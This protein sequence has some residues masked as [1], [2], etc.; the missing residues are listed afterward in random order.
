MT[1]PWLI[2]LPLAMS[3]LTLV[4]R[5]VRLVTTPLTAA[6]FFALAIVLATARAEPLIVLGRSLELA[7]AEA[8]L[9]ALNAALLGW[10]TLASHRIDQSRAA[11]SLALSAF[12]FSVAAVVMENLT[13]A[14]LCLQIAAVLATLLLPIHRAEAAWTALHMLF[15]VALAGALLLVGAWAIQRQAIEPGNV[16]LLHLGSVTLAL[17]FAIVIAAVPFHVW[18][19]PVLACGSILASILSSVSLHS[20][21]LLRFQQLL[22]AELWPEEGA[23][24]ASLLLIS[25]V[26]GVA[27]GS[28]GAWAQ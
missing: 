18:S 5:R 27:V 28:I 15:I 19:P 20:I 21:G 23:F 17:G 24:L 3:L 4:L 22:N 2:G 12:A 7:P 1:I 16:Q 14:I 10:G 26:L 11:Y 13:L 6:T 9:M 8:M 25:G